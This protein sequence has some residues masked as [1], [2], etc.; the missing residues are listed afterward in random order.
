M[1]SNYSHFVVNCTKSKFDVYIGR[2]H[3]LFP[4]PAK[5]GNPFIIKVHGD[6]KQVIEMYREWMKKQPELVKEAKRDLKGKV[7]GCWCAPLDCHGLVLAEI[8]NSD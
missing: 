7:L 5:W 2:K 4:G 3:A 6:R 1:T 8:A